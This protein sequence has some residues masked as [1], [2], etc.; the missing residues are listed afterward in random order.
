MFLDTIMLAI[1]Q[2]AGTF[3]TFGLK[4]GSKKRKSMRKSVLVIRKI[5]ILD[6]I[7][8]IG[9]AIYGTL[10]GTAI[11][12]ATAMASGL[13]NTLIL[14]GLKVSLEQKY[15]AIWTI[16][17]HLILNEKE[18]KKWKK[19]AP[20]MTLEQ[21]ICL[22][23]QYGLKE[24]IVHEA[25]Q[26]YSGPT[27]NSISPDDRVFAGQTVGEWK[28]MG[29]STAMKGREIVPRTAFEIG[30]EATKLTLTATGALFRGIRKGITEKRRE[31]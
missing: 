19:S 31:K 9:F 23:R 12:T 10:S 29:Q 2:V 30:K 3:L 15:D 26:G 22:Y 8:S 25:V 6:I 27:D 28:E 20:T 1:I 17:W 4:S 13:I 18:R 24:T 14:Q 16:E 5:Q 11:G 7:S 21:A